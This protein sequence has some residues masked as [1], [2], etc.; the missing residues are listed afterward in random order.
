MLKTTRQAPTLCGM[1]IRIGALAEASV[2]SSATVW[3]GSFSTPSSRRRQL[4]PRAWTC[5]GL[6]A[7]PLWATW[8]ALALRALAIPAFECLTI[9]F[10]FG[11]LVLVR[12]ER[13][14]PSTG[15]SASHSVLSWVPAIACALGL[16]G[17][18]AFHILATHYI[19][20]A[21]ANLISYL[22]PV[23]IIGIGAALRLFKLRP[24]HL[25][26]LALGLAGA[27]ILMGGGGLSLS[28]A[29]M[30]LAFVSGISWALYCVFRLLWK[31]EPVRV[32]QRGCAI[33][34]VLCA[35]MHLVLEPT[36]MPDL[37][38]LAA[39]AAVG[40]VPLASG[41]LVWDEGFRRGDS[42]LLAVMAYATPLCSA[43]LLI[44][45]GLESLTPGLLLGAV[46]IVIAG[47]LSHAK[48]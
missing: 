24:R 37:G 41:N 5:V 48:A 34:T 33:S 45:L 17:S 40:I 25:V 20:A 31:E 21:E 22:W 43:L 16:T 23:E 28:F 39:S 15:G 7:I 2:S 11:W 30:S 27:I 18:N 47:F 32:L 3:F 26:G 10:L 46:L 38:A 1:V 36:I 13:A 12:L 35:A 29:G 9:A 42:Q 44:A 8:P 19:P 6:I 4:S 14:P